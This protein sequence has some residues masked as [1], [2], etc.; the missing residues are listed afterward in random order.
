M[1]NFIEIPL[2]KRRYKILL[3]LCIL[4]FMLSIW[5]FNYAEN[6]AIYPVPYLTIIGIIGFFLFGIFSVF[7]AKKVIKTNVG[8]TIDKKGIVENTNGLL[9]QKVDWK[10][11]T[12]FVGYN[13]KLILVKVKKPK[14][15]IDQAQNNAQKR[16]LKL[17]ETEYGTPIF[18]D[19]SGLQ[20]SF[21]ETLE[22]LQNRQP[23]YRK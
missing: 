23:N 13:E 5:A 22:L 7:F 17:N 16:I 6:E 1:Q 9:Q 8:L 3:P 20:K 10:D 4:G 18:I 11:I 2:R 21:T 19:A 14:K 12:D 15:Y